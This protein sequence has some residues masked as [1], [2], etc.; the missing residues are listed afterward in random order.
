MHDLASLTRP[1]EWVKVRGLLD[2]AILKVLGQFP[3]ERGELQTRV[4]DETSFPGFV[5]QRVNYFVDEWE[6]VAAWLF[7]PEG[8]DQ[9]PAI[10]CLHDRVAQGK[11]EPAG[12]EGDPL[13][14]F[15]RHYAELGFATLAPDTITAGERISTGLG[16]FDTS[17]YA[18]DYPKLSVMGKLLWDNLYAMD[19]LADTRQVDPSRIG[20]MGHGLGATSALLLSAF[21]ER[22]QACV[23]SCGFTRFADDPQ[24]ARWFD[25][26]GF[27]QLPKLKPAAD[28]GEFPFDWEHVLAMAAPIP[29]LL[30][31]AL[32]DDVLPNTES[33]EAAVT[34]ARTV[35]A[36]LGAAGAL[37]E[38]RH[39]SGRRMT[40][41]T[42][43]AADEWFQ[44]WL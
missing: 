43:E 35:Y 12:I 28:K 17:T 29:N 1:S 31:T 9:V 39:R 34:A 7:L 5:R 16:A 2:A 32:N 19:L 24:V 22:V 33:C 41:E 21:D 8:R 15:A 6:R 4:A 3:K 10:L 20:V 11:D 14:A 13:L 36:L 30:I 38:V 42:L 44:R 25:A 23:A 37:K 27:V 40:P 26:E 18:K